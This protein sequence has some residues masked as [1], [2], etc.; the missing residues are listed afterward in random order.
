MGSLFEKRNRAKQ[1]AIDAIERIVEI[2]DRDDTFEGLT[3]SVLAL[4][5]IKAH[6]DAAIDKVTGMDQDV[7]F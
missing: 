1:N 6:L 3:V 4:K 5:E 7:V 2:G